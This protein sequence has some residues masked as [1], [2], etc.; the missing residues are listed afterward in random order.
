MA[1]EVGTSTVLTM[2]SNRLQELAGGIVEFQEAVANRDSRSAM[3]EP[4]L[5]HLAPGS[6][7]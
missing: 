6:C 3:L 1:E 5:Q 2:L 7:S 4:V